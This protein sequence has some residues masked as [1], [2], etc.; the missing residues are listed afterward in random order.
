MTNPIDN[1]SPS[2]PRSET[3]DRP[4]PE[5]PGTFRQVGRLSEI[6]AALRNHRESLCFFLSLM[7]GVA[8]LIEPLADPAED[9]GRWLAASVLVAA[10]CFANALLVRRRRSLLASHSLVFLLAA[11]V[12]IQIYHHTGISWTFV[13]PPLVLFLHPIR[14][15]LLYLLLIAL[16]VTGGLAIGHVTLVLRDHEP[17]EFWCSL[18]GVTAVSA[19][20]VRGLGKAV[21]AVTSVAF[22]DPLT[23]LYQ[24]DL[25]NDLAGRQIEIA[26]RERAAFALLALDVD[27]LKAVNDRIGHAAGDRVLCAVAGVLADTLRGADISARFGGDEFV[28]LL[29]DLDQAQA[30]ETARRLHERI[31]RHPELVRHQSIA[32]ITV[33]IGIAVYPNHGATLHELFDAADTALLRAKAAGKN[34]I[35]VAAPG[36]APANSAQPGLC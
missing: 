18:L 29:P 22:R 8:S 28:V 23:D 11:F 24:R 4:R 31:V 32:S 7:V 9:G 1:A 2:D 17:F 36:D 21:T 30:L 34:G 3:R 16:V 12:M 6:D 14:R 35:V 10:G 15:G 20:L 25:F 33:S 27:N 13:L 19:L 5:T 26:R